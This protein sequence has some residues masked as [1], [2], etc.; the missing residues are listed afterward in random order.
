MN[1]TFRRTI[2]YFL[3]IIFFI[4]SVVMA[5]ETIPRYIG[6][7]EGMYI[8][9]TIQGVIDVY[10][11]NG[12]GQL[13][14]DDIVIENTGTFEVNV[15]LQNVENN[16][17]SSISLAQNPIESTSSKKEVYMYLEN[18]SDGY[19]LRYTIAENAGWYNLGKLA[20]GETMILAIDGE[21]NTNCYT[22]NQADILKT[23][24]KFIFEKIELDIE[25]TAV[26]VLEETE[27]ETP[28]EVL[29]EILEETPEEVL[30]EILEETLEEVPE[31]K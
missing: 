21:A 10:N 23:S 31:E 26:E 28:E 15:I 18:I 13:V 5:S 30:G 29:E 12:K 4:P 25:D 14:Y 7:Q 19:G 24:M 9:Q 2:I 16:E 20:P 22:W 6:E 3:S 17:A 27:E 8:T 11:I 1:R